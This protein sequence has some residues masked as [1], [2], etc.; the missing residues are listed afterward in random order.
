MLEEVRKG[1]P[2]RRPREPDEYHARFGMLEN[3]PWSAEH[4]GWSLHAGVTVAAGDDETGRERVC[5][6]VVHRAVARNAYAGPKTDASRASSSSRG[7]RRA[8]TCRWHQCRFSRGSPRWYLRHASTRALRRRAVERLE[9]ASACRPERARRGFP[10]PRPMARRHHPRLTRATQRE[11]SMP[12]A[13]PWTRP[14]PCTTRLQLEGNLARG[15]LHAASNCIDWHTL[16]VHV[17]DIDSLTCTKGG[18]QLRMNW[19][20]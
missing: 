2:G 16:L 18:G 6:C 17:D 12:R 8:P 19:N 13:R 20:G 10:P 1:S 4:Q 11:P 15:C 5:R 9:A 7:A 14:W 3:T